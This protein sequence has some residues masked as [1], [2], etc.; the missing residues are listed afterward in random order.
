MATN[1]DSIVRNIRAKTE[2]MTGQLRGDKSSSTQSAQDKIFNALSTLVS[3]QNLVSP[4]PE[5]DILNEDWKKRMEAQN[6]EAEYAAS[7]PYPTWTPRK[8]D[9]PE[10]M[11]N[12]PAKPNN[13]IA[14]PK[15]EKNFFEKFAGELPQ[16]FD[17]AIR[18]ISDIA[19][20]VQD[21]FT[22]QMPTDEFIKQF[23]EAVKAVSKKYNI[24]ENIMR[25]MAALETQTGIGRQP[26][27][28]AK[29]RNNIYNIQAYDSNPDMARRY[30]S[31]MEGVTD[32]ANLI[33]RDPR[34]KKAYA[35][36]ND[37]VKMIQEIKR[38]GYATDPNYVNKVMS[39]PEFKS[40]I[41]QPSKPVP[42]PT[43]SQ[44]QYYRAVKDVAPKMEPK[45][46][47]SSYKPGIPMPKV[48]PTKVPTPP[49]AAQPNVFQNI[50]KLFTGGK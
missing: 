38:A 40:G 15:M 35:V 8:I 25:A 32:F 26:L 45:K 1:I 7:L 42:Q 33:S 21:V 5:N 41:K 9:Y 2:K 3:P 4:I 13:G 50:Y 46:I 37:P 29:S 14:K 11:A 27:G 39:T 47:L 31:V 49:P 20:N 18:P 28:Y 30:P 12:A 10:W 24:P 34:Y 6:A 23:D 44:E 43:M 22:P 19:G 48:Q 36:R 17:E 16:K